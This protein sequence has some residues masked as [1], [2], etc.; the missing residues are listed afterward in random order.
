MGAKLQRGSFIRNPAS[1]AES[2]IMC[3][4]TS[5]KS[6]IA[7]LSAKKNTMLTETQ[8]KEI[9]RLIS[10]YNQVRVS[11]IPDPL[12]EWEVLCKLKVALD[13]VFDP[14]EFDNDVEVGV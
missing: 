9:L 2:P 11:K 4:E 1:G 8:E 5:K 6:H 3:A 13:E 14:P 7:A 10:Q 12:M